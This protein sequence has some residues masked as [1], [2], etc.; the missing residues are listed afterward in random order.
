MLVI[1][2]S[3]ILPVVHVVE[4]DPLQ[5]ELC[6]M[7]VLKTMFVPLTNGKVVNPVF[8]D[9][10]KSESVHEIVAVVFGADFCQRSR[11]L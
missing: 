8:L 3:G 11:R 1:S 6:Q 10:M 9:G 7:A 5:A 2:I 4:H